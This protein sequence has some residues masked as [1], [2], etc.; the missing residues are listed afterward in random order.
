MSDC[1]RFEVEGL[2]YLEGSLSAPARDAFETHLASCGPCRDTA[3]AY[4]LILDSYRELPES[5]AP[6]ESARRILASARQHLRP[7]PA[8]R[9]LLAAALVAVLVLLALLLARGS[10]PDAGADALVERADLQRATGDLAAAEASLEEALSSAPG[11]PR[12]AEILH[13]LGEISLARGEFV[14]ADAWLSTLL[15]E[16]RDYLER[17]AVLLLHGQVLE[18][19]GEL[20]QAREAYL[21]ASDVAASGEEAQRRL[22]A[23]SERSSL[24]ALQALGYAGE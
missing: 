11:G 12:A 23:L 6:P 17:G 24:E 16:H 2:E 10:A 19:L 21:A 15:R 7:A 4:R 22:R 5:P 18:A 3:Q 1:T 20:D 8:R 13:R 14:K 9:P